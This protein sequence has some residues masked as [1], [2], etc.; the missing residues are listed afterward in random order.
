MAMTSSLDGFLFFCNGLANPYEATG[1]FMISLLYLFQA[2]VASYG[3]QEEG[4]VFIL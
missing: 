1:Y 4:E 3:A 2:Y